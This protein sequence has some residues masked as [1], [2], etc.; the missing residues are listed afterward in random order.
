MSSFRIFISFLQKQL[1][2]SHNA[3]CQMAFKAG[4]LSDSIRMICQA[5]FTQPEATWLYMF[6]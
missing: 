3:T 5:A 6:V 1:L 4:F 2:Q